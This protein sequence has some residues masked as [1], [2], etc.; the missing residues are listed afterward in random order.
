MGKYGEQGNYLSKIWRAGELI[1][2]KRRTILDSVDQNMKRGELFEKNTEN[3][4]TI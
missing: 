4:R 2:Q 1:E 3:R